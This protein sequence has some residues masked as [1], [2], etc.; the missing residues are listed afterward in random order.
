[1]FRW[2]IPFTNCDDYALKDLWPLLL[3]LSCLAEEN[4]V[5]EQG[6]GVSASIFL[7]LKSDKSVFAKEEK[8]K[9]TPKNVK[10]SQ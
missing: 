7:A 1:M 8:K 2:G 10:L 3:S 9:P 5:M 4:F 6:P